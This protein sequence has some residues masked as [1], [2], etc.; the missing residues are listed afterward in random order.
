MGKMG[1]IRAQHIFNLDNGHTPER[2]YIKN[3]PSMDRS[4]PIGNNKDR[5]NIKKSHLL[6]SCLPPYN[7]AKGYVSQSIVALQ[8]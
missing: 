5:K 7:R 4:M 3:T 2:C 6:L 1:E 8:P